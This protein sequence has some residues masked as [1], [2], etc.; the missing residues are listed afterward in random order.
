MFSFPVIP[1]WEI[2]TGGF[3]L[4]PTAKLSSSDSKTPRPDPAAPAGSTPM[5]SLR[6]DTFAEPCPVWV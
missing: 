4:R 3:A 1:M 6:D 5:R 2:T